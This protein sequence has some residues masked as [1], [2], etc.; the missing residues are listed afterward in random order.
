MNER[1]QPGRA[2]HGLLLVHGEPGAAMKWA[3]RGLVAVQVVPQGAWTALLPVEPLA[4][5][6]EPYD[7]PAAVLVSRPLPRRLRPALGLL[8]VDDRA[9]VVLHRGGLRHAPRWLVWEPGVGHARTPELALATPSELAG[10]AGRP[11][12]ARDVARVVADRSGD[13]VRLLTDLLTVLRLPGA[14]LLGPGVGLRGQ[15]VAPTAQAVHKFDARM[16]EIARHHR[17]LEDNQ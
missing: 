4:R 14:E 10:A 13:A 11:R 17:E 8:V 9:T 12:A 7:D 1:R 2:T 15:V 5:S 6:A 16:A 3:R